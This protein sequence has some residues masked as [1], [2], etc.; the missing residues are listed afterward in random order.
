MTIDDTKPPLVRMNL[1]YE[2]RA[3]QAMRDAC[4]LTG[5]SRTDVTNNA[6]VAYAWLLKRCDNGELVVRAPDGQLERVVL[7]ELL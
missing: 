3:V 1:N 4:D 5:R 7:L 6:L 2:P